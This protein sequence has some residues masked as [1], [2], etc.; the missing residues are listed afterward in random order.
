MARTTTHHNHQAATSVDPRFTRRVLAKAAAG[1]AAAAALAG[2][3]A[4]AT[5]PAI[6]KDSSTQGAEWWAPEGVGGTGEA[7]E[8]TADH[9]FHAIAPHWTADPSISGAV[10]ISVSADG[11]TWTEPTIVGPALADAGPADR[12]G[13]VF[14]HLLM[15][16]EAQHVRARPLDAN[17]VPAALPGLAFTYIDASAGPTIDDVSSPATGVGGGLVQ[18]PIISRDQWGA[19]LAYGGTDAGTDGWLAEH[20]TVEHIVIHHSDTPSFR[21]PLV[22]IRS[23][24]YYHAV[25][26][27]WGDIGYNYLVD[28]LGNVYEGRKGGENVVGGHA[29]QYAY[30]SA[31]ICSMGNFSLQTST[32]EAIG[33]LVWITAWAGRALDPLGQKDF[34]EVPN[35]PTI[36]G[37][38]DVVNSSCPG[39]AL[40]ADLP[41][42]RTAVAEVIAGS[43]NAELPSD[44]AAGDVVETT[45]DEANLRSRPGIG[46]TV[47][48]TLPRGQVLTIVEGPSST[49]GYV[50][51]RVSGDADAG[52]LA[53]TTFAPSATTPPE[54]VYTNGSQIEVA[55]NLLNLRSEPNLNSSLVASLPQ[56]DVATVVGGPQGDGTVVWLQVDS[57]LGTGWVDQQF[58]APSGRAWV[59]SN[60]TVGD[61]VRVSDDHL[62]MRVDAATRAALVAQLPLNT[63]GSV[64]GGPRQSAGVTWLQISTDL[65]TGWVVE[66]YLSEGQA[67]PPAEAKFDVGAQ[68]VVDTDSLNMRAE[69]GGNSRVVA[70]LWHGVVGAVIDVPVTRDGYT[71]YRIETDEGSGWVVE[72]FLADATS[73]DAPAAGFEP[74]TAIT[75][76][77]DVVTLRS[78]A[79]TQG[80]AVAELKHGAA[81]SVVGGTQQLEGLT[82]VEATFDGAT[83]WLATAYIGR[84]T[85][86]PAYAGNLDV[87]MTAEITS[88]HVNIRPSASLSATVNGQL[89]PGDTVTIVDGPV[90]SEGY[91]WFSVEG[92]WS[93]WV[94]DVW[95]APTAPAG[96]TIGSTVRVFGGELNLR[97]GPSTAD[98]VATILPD[99]AVVEVLDGPQQGDGHDWYRVSSSRY[100]TG[101]AVADW[102][103]RA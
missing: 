55:T 45:V 97:S 21:D 81:G 18:P 52:W 65:G 68:I 66:E 7:L 100:G 78:S 88:D 62:N 49:D 58:V 42:I 95:L 28:H 80:S 83:G 75:V 79:S 22:E 23:I 12:E 8:F 48:A 69:A 6:A 13:R 94:V 5:R 31:G 47:E 61:T 27:G 33:A 24:H 3:T 90:M 77:T 91:T 1:F 84:A 37:H 70:Q 16:D 76:T 26:R 51:Y 34:H 20:R 25:S 46:G 64:V 2:G 99:G 74:G 92:K 85:A 17:G 67:P 35:C 30:G 15:T 71:W 87:G 57:N 86:S 63:I 59:S 38:R 39:D 96:I 60:F 93:G 103:E 44:Y 50:W 10:E 101:W 11:A 53:T 73:A 9:A 36:C 32:P 14:G 19:A 4:P 72:T 56:G 89:W 54:R 40:Y 29:Y 102:L 82:W 41:Y 98:A 43:R